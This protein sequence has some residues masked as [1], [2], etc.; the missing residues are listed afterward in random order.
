MNTNLQI[1]FRNIEPSEEAGEWIR[2]EAAKLN[3]FYSR[4]TG[5]HVTIDLPHRHHK[6]GNQYQI[7]IDLNVPQ[8]K[9]VVKREPH[10]NARLRR[11]PENKVRKFA[12]VR[13]LHKDLRTAIG[14][15]FKAAGRRLQDYARRQRGDTKTPAGRLKVGAAVRFSEARGEKGPQA[16]T[17]RVL[18]K[19]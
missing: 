10:S 1:T 4:L 14:E 3:S 11:L 17:A 18:A 15:A 8:G 16:S 13:P 12:E 6:R 19:Q 9:L 7:R 5:C 2:T